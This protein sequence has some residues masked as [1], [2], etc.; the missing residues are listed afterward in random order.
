MLHLSENIIELLIRYWLFG[1]CMPNNDCCTPLFAAPLSGDPRVAELLLTAGANKET[2]S[3]S[4]GT[5][6]SVACAN[7]AVELV[8]G[9]AGANKATFNN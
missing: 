1:A 5:T 3:C 2:P 9:F 8:I 6:L 4:G 7:Q